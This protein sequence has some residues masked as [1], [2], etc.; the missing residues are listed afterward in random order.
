MSAIEWSKKSQLTER[1]TM[2]S[3]DTVRVH[4]RVREGDRERIQIFEGCPSS[5]C[6]AA[7][8]ARRSR[9]QSVDSAR[10]WMRI[11]PAALADDSEGSRSCGR[12]KFAAPSCTICAT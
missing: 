8:R 12:R 2:K 10:A 1:P 4:V 11:F 9:A 5:G 7:A 6:T 3:G